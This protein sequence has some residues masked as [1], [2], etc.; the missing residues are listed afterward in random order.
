[1]VV[2]V[3][4]TVVSPLIGTVL[5]PKEEEEQEVTFVEVQER[6]ELCPGRILIGLAV[7]VTVGLSA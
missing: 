6:V 3:G 1:M 2:E 5:S 7:R 4:E